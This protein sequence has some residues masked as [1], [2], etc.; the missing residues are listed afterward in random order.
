ML[1]KEVSNTILKVFGMTRPGI[2]PRSP[3]PFVNTLPTRAISRKFPNTYKYVYEH[4]R[5]KTTD[6][7]LFKIFKWR[8]S[9]LLFIFRMS[10]SRWWRKDLIPDIRKITRRLD[11]FHLKNLKRKQFVVFNRRC[12]SND[13]LSIYLSIYIYIYI[14]IYIGSLFF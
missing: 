3:G 10:G 8:R 14:Y 12:L 13:L 2:E 9:G 5:L 7:F 1:S 6:C 4:V 11:R